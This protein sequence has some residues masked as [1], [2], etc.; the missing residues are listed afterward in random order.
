MTKRLIE[1][2]VKEA[3]EWTKMLQSA[4]DRRDAKPRAYALEKLRDALSRLDM[5]VNN[6]NPDWGYTTPP[7]RGSNHIG[8][9]W[10]DDGWKVHDKNRG[11]IL[12]LSRDEATELLRS[13]TTPSPVAQ[14]VREALEEARIVISTADDVARDLGGQKDDSE[15]RAEYLRV[16]G[17]IDQT[18]AVLSGEAK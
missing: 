18:L 4:I 10:D 13:I 3:I 9:D 5:R 14:D 2:D 7:R 17:L 11:V 12:H 6:S 1:H 15:E 16:I 8:V